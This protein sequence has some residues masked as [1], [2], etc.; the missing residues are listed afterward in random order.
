MITFMKYEAELGDTELHF[1]N[2]EGID[3]LSGEN[4]IVVGTPHLSE[5]VYK[6][7]GYHLGMEIQTDVLAMRRIQ[8]KDYEFNFMTYKN[9]ALRNLQTF[10]IGKEL[11]QC[12]GRARLLRNDCTVLVLSNFPCEQ[13]ELIQDDY[14]ETTDGGGLMKACSPDM[15]GEL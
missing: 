6:L 14:L 9:E 12:I 11:E 7:I 2:A 8:Y 5:F 3:R 13:A 1:G 4:V 10:F 15:A